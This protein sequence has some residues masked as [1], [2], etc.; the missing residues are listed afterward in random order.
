MAGPLGNIPGM[1]FDPVRNRYFPTPTAALAGTSGGPSSSSTS[2]ASNPASRRPHPSG[3]SRSLSHKE[4]MA[5]KRPR[6]QDELL[7]VLDRETGKTRMVTPVDPTRWQSTIPSRSNRL[8]CRMAT[9]V[10]EMCL[11]KRCVCVDDQM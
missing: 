7:P 4:H 5:R 1:S 2:S 10:S 11:V 6:K 3:T 8:G 9:T